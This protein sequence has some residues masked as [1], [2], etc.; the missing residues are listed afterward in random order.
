MNGWNSLYK[1]RG[2]IQ[3]SLSEK[4]IDAVNFFKQED[5]K[6]VLDLGC[7]TGKHTVYFYK[8]GF[9][10]YGCDFSEAALGIAKKIFPEVKFEQCGLTSLLYEDGFFDGILCNHVIQS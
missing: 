10:I 9:Q 4:V 6:R 2:I 1:E 7:G 8:E 3:K 5:L